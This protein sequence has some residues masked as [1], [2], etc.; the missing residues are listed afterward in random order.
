MDIIDH[1]QSRAQIDAREN[2]GTI[3]MSQ[4]GV[5]ARRDVEDLEAQNEAEDN[6]ESEE[7]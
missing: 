2:V 6:Q 4:M 7:E 5:N 1:H 3:Q